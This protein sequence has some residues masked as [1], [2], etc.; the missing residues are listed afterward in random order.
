[1]LL[2]N[3]VVLLLLVLLRE[4]GYESE[5]PKQPAL[6]WL[7]LAAASVGA[8]MICKPSEIVIDPPESVIVRNLINERRIP[9]AE[10]SH[11]EL[12]PNPSRTA[13][14]GLPS[15]D[16]SL[17]NVVMYFHDGTQLATHVGLSEWGARLGAKRITE[18]T[19]TKLV[20]YRPL[21]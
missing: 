2:F 5:V 9:F 14:D 7:G 10:V 11:V 8:W 13:L 17:F 4:F 3:G 12:Q 19:G 21:Q 18:V 16:L 15:L 1:V 20:R 6:I